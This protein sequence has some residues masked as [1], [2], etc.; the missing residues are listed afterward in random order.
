MRPEHAR[1]LIRV[2]EGF[3]PAPQS[4]YDLG[5][6]SGTFTLA[7]AG[8]LAAGSTICAVDRE[9]RPLDA[10]P[11]SYEGTSIRKLPANFLDATFA[12]PALDGILM[13]NSLHFVKEQASLLTKISRSAKRLLF[14]EYD[15]G[16]RSI[17]RPYPLPF[18]K[19]RLL[20]LESGFVS[21]VRLAER[22][23]RFG[24]TL[25]SALAEH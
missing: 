4:W 18:N 20:T 10:I 17:W 3:G 7:L 11:D 6:G 8:L 19:L 22:P 5:C 1:D 24:G 25:Y 2:K 16:S 23:S 21:F 9:K 14:V 15:G 13:A 12:L